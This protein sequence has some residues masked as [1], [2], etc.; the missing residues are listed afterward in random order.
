MQG[1]QSYACVCSCISV[2][3]GPCL[4]VHRVLARKAVICDLM[5]YFDNLIGISIPSGNVLRKLCGGS[6]GLRYALLAMLGF[7]IAF[8]I[9]AYLRIGPMSPLTS[10]A[11]RSAKQFLSSLRGF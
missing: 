8:F 7:S 1:W 9:L 10:F 3:F 5:C 11:W 2:R 4:L 6:Q